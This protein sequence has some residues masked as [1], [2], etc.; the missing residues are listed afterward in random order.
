MNLL[1]VII[2]GLL[3]AFSASIVGIWLVLRKEALRSDIVS[4]SVLP[5]IA[6]MFLLLHQK[7]L[8]VLLLGAFFTAL[9]SL[10][11]I[12]FLSKHTKLKKDTLLALTL[13]FFFAWGVWLLVKIQEIKNPNKSGLNHFIFGKMASILPQDIILAAILFLLVVIINIIFRRLLFFTTFDK[14]FSQSV[15]INHQIVSTLIKI[16][17][18]L[19]IV[20]GLQAVGVTMISALLITPPTIAILLAK[21]DIRKVFVLVVFINVFTVFSGILLSYFFPKTPTG[22]WIVIIISVLFL[23]VSSFKR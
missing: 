12:D 5:G 18:V 14:E 2:G 7:H 11:S 21:K 3:I 8:W 23:L 1:Y 16:M 19:S 9:L 13:S 22:P 6:L 17:S 15:G 10:S 20:I 4:H